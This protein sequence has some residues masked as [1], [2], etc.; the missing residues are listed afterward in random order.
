MDQKLQTNPPRFS[1]VC[2]PC[3]PPGPW[4]SP[5]PEAP[6]FEG[7]FFP[8]CGCGSK[9]RY[10]NGTLVSGNMDQNL[11]KPS[12]LILSHTQVLG[13]EKPPG[14]E[15]PTFPMPRFKSVDPERVQRLSASAGGRRPRSI[16]HRKWPWRL[17]SQHLDAKSV[18]ILVGNFWRVPS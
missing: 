7:R 5:A 3:A 11:R 15:T 4:T 10:Q 1:G 16:G 6:E 2:F 8:P 17:G 18:G 13:P 12:C 9:N 14:S